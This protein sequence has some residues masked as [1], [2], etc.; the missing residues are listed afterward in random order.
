MRAI[1]FLLL[2]TVMTS[3]ARAD[4]TFSL[5]PPHGRAGRVVSLRVDDTFGCFPSDG[6]TSVERNGNTI[7]TTAWIV[8]SAPAGGCPAQWIAP[9]FFPLGTFTPGYY[10]V[11]VVL[12][13]SSPAPSPCTVRATLPLAVFAS[14]GDRFTVPALSGVAAIG[15]VLAIVLVGS[16]VARDR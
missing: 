10:E 9:R 1:V 5:D 4:W 12:C 8:D 7:T 15:L 11:E 16:L 2:L 14:S 3:D 6:L 13:T